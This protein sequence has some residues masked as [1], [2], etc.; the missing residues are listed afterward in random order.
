MKTFAL[1]MLLMFVFVQLA[2]A[3]AGAPLPGRTPIVVPPPK[4]RVIDSPPPKEP[5]RDKREGG[6]VKGKDE[7]PKEEKKQKEVPA[8]GYDRQG[9]P[10]RDYM[11][12]HNIP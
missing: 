10:S 5:I 6:E 9:S 2:F 1:I 11:K 4:P 3:Q 12:K 7:K 8:Q